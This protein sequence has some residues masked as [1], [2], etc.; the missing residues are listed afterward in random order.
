MRGGDE[1]SG[2]AFSSVDLEERAR[3]DHLLRAI[4]GHERGNELRAMRVT[5]QV[6]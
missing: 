4:R 3:S 5:P 2:Q 6:A 1:R